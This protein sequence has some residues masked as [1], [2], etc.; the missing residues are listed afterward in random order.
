MSAERDFSFGLEGPAKEKVVERE[1][2]KNVQEFTGL[3][4][5]ER[6][7]VKSVVAKIKTVEV[8]Q[9]SNVKYMLLGI[10]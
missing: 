8:C 1:E 4:E 7:T 3:E 2:E 5:R 10:Y 6:A 9:S